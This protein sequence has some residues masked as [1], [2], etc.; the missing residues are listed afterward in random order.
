MSEPERLLAREVAVSPTFLGADGALAYLEGPTTDRRVVIRD[1]GM[2]ET[3]EPPSAPSWIVG[4]PTRP[5]VICG[6][7]QPGTECVD[8]VRVTRTG[9]ATHLSD[10]SRV[11][12][13][14][15]GFGPDGDRFAY[16]AN[17]RRS[18]HFDVYVQERDRGEQAAT[19]VCEG[20]GWFNVAGWSPG[21]DRLAL[22]ETEANTEKRL[23]VLDVETGDRRRITGDDAARF[24]GV[25]WGPDGSAV[26]C[27]T[28]LDRELTAICRVGLDDGS[29]ETV[30]ESDWNVEAF[31]L[32][33]ETRTAV[34]VENASGYSKLSIGSLSSATEIEPTHVD[35]FEPGVIES[36]TVSPGADAVVARQSSDAV[37]SRIARYE[38]AAGE[39]ATVTE[40]RVRDGSLS[41]R[42]VE[43][44]ST[45]GRSIPAVLT[46]PRAAEDG[47]VAVIVDV[48]GGPDGQ[49]RP[50]YN[51]R[52]QY[53]L[54]RG[55]GYFEPNV[56]GS[57]GY[58]A[59]YRALDDGADR[60]DA[61][62]DLV[63][64]GEWLERQP[65]VAGEELVLLGESAGGLAVLLALAVAPER[66]RAGIS[67]AGITDLVSYLEETSAWRR[68]QRQREYGS[69]ET[70]RD[71]L[72][73]LSP[74]SH[75]DSIRAPVLLVH[76]EQDERVPV[77]QLYAFERAARAAG[78]D[79]E[80]LVF[81]SA[82]HRIRDPNRRTEVLER[83]HE[84]AR[85][86]TRESDAGSPASGSNAGSR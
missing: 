81:Q 7:Q 56:R 51:P 12:R 15:G 41:R 67:I 60:W 23:H 58:G 8:F 4:S 47:A 2:T 35:V 27:T 76:G 30:Y 82:G 80:T 38:P 31:G 32:D 65:R 83:C 28:D 59:S 78:I 69:L 39:C 85:S 18:D 36:V 48:H 26:Y 21:G 57:S 50:R 42:R 33:P 79:V 14:W 66:F 70:D 11:N 49:H 63:A 43:F 72:R 22:V 55:F 25:S 86:V 54:R 16:T 6:I 71:L 62:D 37:P 73:E 74:V 17:H 13:W 61:I 20:R 44:E 3:I 77:A 19:R 29:I 10:G 46:L 84:L 45:D 40:T 64:G 24:S 5:E 52:K 53:F 9:D 68:A 75:V 1:G 34:F